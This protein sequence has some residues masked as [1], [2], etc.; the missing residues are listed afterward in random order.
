[1]G[2]YLVVKDWG[3]L[4]H[5]DLCWDLPF[6]CT[7]QIGVI[8]KRHGVMYHL[9]ADDT[10]V[11]ISFR[12]DSEVDQ[13][14]ARRGIQACIAEIR[15]CIVINRLKLNDGK[16]ESVIGTPIFPQLLLSGTWVFLDSPM[17]M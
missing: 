2:K 8:L 11:Y 3:L 12:V 14:T 13:E 17:N 15:V 4:Y 9:Q 16:T 10:Q 1:M 7:V 5:K 6:Q